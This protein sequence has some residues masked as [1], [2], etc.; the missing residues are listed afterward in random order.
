MPPTPEFNPD[1]VAYFEQAGWEAYYD[2]N[3]P[4]TFWL[5]VGL[6]REQFRMGWWLAD[7]IL[8]RASPRFIESLCDFDS[9]AKLASPVRTCALSRTATTTA[10]G[11]SP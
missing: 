6:N 1:R 8:A 10:H 7:Y 5:L 11:T 9:S 3:W 2:R 4:R